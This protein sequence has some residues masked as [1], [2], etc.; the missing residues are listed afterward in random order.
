MSLYPESPKYTPSQPVPTITLAPSATRSLSQEDPQLSF[1]DDRDTGR[2]SP[3]AVPS[4]SSVPFHLLLL[5]RFSRGPSQDSIPWVDLFCYL[6]SLFKFFILPFP[7]KWL[8]NHEV[9]ELPRDT[10]VLSSGQRQC[11]TEYGNNQQSPP[12]RNDTHSLPRT[13][14]LLTDFCYTFLVL[15]FFSLLGVPAE[16]IYCESTGSAIEKVYSQLLC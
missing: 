7:E 13:I 9:D 15:T 3:T 12:N 16:V 11:W 8:Y 6:L 10:P 2:T 5:P 4:T 14:A 1:R